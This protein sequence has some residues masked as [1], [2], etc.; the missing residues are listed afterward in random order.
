MR[1]REFI[2]FLGGAAAAWP[3]AARA[4]QPAMPVVGFLRPIPPTAYPETLDAFKQ[5]LGEVGYAEGR[6]VI[7][8]HRWSAGHYEQLST[9]AAELAQ[10]RV[11]VIFTG[12]G[13]VTALAAKA[14]TKT[15]PTVFVVGDDPIRAG[16]VSSI[17]RP[18]GNITGITLFAFTLEM[19][20]LEL[21]A[22]LAPL[23]G[24]IA[25]LRNPNAPEAESQAIA[26]KTA[27]EKLGR[28]LHVLSASTEDEIDAAFAALPKLRVGALLVVNDVYFS[29]RSPQI[30]ALTRRNSI[31]AIF[32][33]RHHVVAGGLISYG[34]SLT[35]AYRQAGV[36]T[37]RILKGERPGDLPVMQPTRFE[38]VINLTTAKA[39]G[40]DV[41]PMLLARADEVIE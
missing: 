29:A 19:K 1:R 35:G 16:I 15:I 18:E 17:N 27:A 41:P 31:P 40:L 34:T 11:S 26:I 5:G 38:L 8:E 22:E 6:H 32:D 3:I 9:L 13:A 4:Q 28:Q 21:L 14:A 25:V 2:S 20:K 33:L 36:Y 12:G 30:I 37:G 24:T 10:R 23:A 7:I 39:L